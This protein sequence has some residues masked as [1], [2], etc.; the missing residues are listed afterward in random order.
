M[1]GQYGGSPVCNPDPAPRS[2]STP[3]LPGTPAESPGG[4]RVYGRSTAEK[5]KS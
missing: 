5:Q 3:T 2:S 1:K 4:W